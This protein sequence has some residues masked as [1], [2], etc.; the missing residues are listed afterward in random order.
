MDAT[1]GSQLGTLYFFGSGDWAF[2][3]ANGEFEA[4]EGG[5]DFLKF[6][7][8][9]RSFPVDKSVNSKYKEGLLSSILF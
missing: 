1:S 9:N 5:L 7:D 3:A 6:I 4:S 8:N 2:I